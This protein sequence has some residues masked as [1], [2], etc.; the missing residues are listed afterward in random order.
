VAAAAPGPMTVRVKEGSSRYWLALRV[1]NDGNPLSTVEVQAGTAWKALS[2]TDYNYWIAQNGAGNG[3]F[4]VRVTDSTGRRTLLTG[5]A[6]SP[7]AV[8]TPGSTKAAPRAAPATGT[9]R[10]TPANGPASA[11]ATTPAAGSALESTSAAGDPPAGSASMAVA[12][13]SP[14]PVA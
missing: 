11:P 8:Q 14:S 3:P 2:R 9:P 12:A 1:D 4:T 7:G 6:L 5:V 13:G 10:S